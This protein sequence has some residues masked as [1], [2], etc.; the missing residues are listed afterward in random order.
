M[1]LCFYYQILTR[2]THIELFYSHLP[3]KSRKIL[4]EISHIW[5]VARLRLCILKCA[6][7]CSTSGMSQN[8]VQL[9]IIEHIKNGLCSSSFSKKTIFRYGPET[10]NLAKWGSWCKNVIFK[11]I[12]EKI[13]PEWSIK[14]CFY[15]PT[16]RYSLEERTLSYFIIIYLKNEGKFTKFRTE[17][18]KIAQNRE[19]F[20]M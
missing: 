20:G 12:G 13:W 2:R 14:S 15:A 4:T 16:I 6:Q 9:M 8:D 11:S 19:Y 18:E 17:F 10:E 7:I 5:L 1:F 3:Q